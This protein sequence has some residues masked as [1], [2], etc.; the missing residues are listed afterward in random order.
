MQTNDASSLPLSVPS[1]K[2]WPPQNPM[3]TPPIFPG[4]RPTQ[5]MLLQRVHPMAFHHIKHPQTQ[6]P[7]HKFTQHHICITASPETTHRLHCPHQHP[8]RSPPT[9][10]RHTH[11]QPYPHDGQ[12]ALPYLP[13]AHTAMWQFTNLQLQHCTHHDLT[14]IWQFTSPYEY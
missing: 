10:H 6:P 1:P 2:W 13:H 5:T 9:P 12:S 3:Q 11:Q 8:Q 7:L 14:A 4:P